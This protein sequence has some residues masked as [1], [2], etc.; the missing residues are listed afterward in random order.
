MNLTV[1]EISDKIKSLDQEIKKA[2]TESAQI[3][4]RLQESMNNLNKNFNVKSVE[5]GQEKIKQMEKDS[6]ELQNKI[7]KAYEELNTMYE[8]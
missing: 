8:W 1:D 7:Q 2:E 6:L 4:G 3:S 5:E